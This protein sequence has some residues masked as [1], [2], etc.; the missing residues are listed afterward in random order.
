MSIRKYGRYW[1]VVDADGALVCIT[2]YKRGAMEVIRR[3]Q[4]LDNAQ[5]RQDIHGPVDGDRCKGEER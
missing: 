3:L 1:K 5:Q 2:V 4:A